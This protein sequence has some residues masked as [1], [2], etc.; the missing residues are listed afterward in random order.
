M[1]RQDKG[2]TCQG[3]MTGDN[4]FITSVMWLTPDIVVA[5]T[6]LNELLFV[7]GGDLKLAYPAE[8]IEVIDLSKSKEEY[9]FS[10]SMLLTKHTLK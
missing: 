1:S 10:F 7:E 4:R 5:G 8:L 9:F 6:S 2:F 3:T